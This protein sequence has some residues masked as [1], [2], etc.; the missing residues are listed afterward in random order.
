MKVA[1][2][3]TKKKPS[4][5]PTRPVRPVAKIGKSGH[6]SASRSTPVVKTK[7]TLRPKVASRPVAIKAKPVAVTAKSPTV[8]VKALA[9][10]NGH[11]PNGSGKSEIVK[12]AAKVAP[13]TATPAVKYPDP[14]ISADKDISSKSA[15]GIVKDRIFLMVPDPHWLHCHWE[16]SFQSVQRAEAALGQDW[17]GAKPVIRLFDVTSQDTT[18]TAETS[19]RDIVIHGGC[20]HWYID[21]TQPPRTYRADIGYITRRGHFHPLCRSNVVTPPK[22]G[23][24]ENLEESFASDVEDKAVEKLLSMTHGFDGPN[25]SGQ[26]RDL[27]DEQVKR[28]SKDASLGNGTAVPEK[29][30]KFAFDL[31]AELIVYGKTDPTATVKLQ[32]EPLKVRPDGTFTMRYSLTDGRQIIPAV[33]TSSDGMEERTIVLAVERNTKHLDPLVHDLYGEG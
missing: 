10:G 9:N 19:V 12:V 29:L 15:K 27:F 5:K 22:V 1:T 7:T 33:A 14:V 17:Y 18:S 30:K 25:G 26:L 21:I 4:G 32:N 13:K 16:L 6:K 31:N 24:M 2:S 20:N 8:P 28:S 23:E 11:K 3:K